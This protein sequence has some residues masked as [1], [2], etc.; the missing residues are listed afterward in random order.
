[1]H[2]SQ[3]PTAETNR[4]VTVGISESLNNGRLNVVA[5]SWLCEQIPL[6]LQ[7]KQLNVS[8]IV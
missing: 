2:G 1:M 5:V 3:Q 7:I 8:A 6:T 4:D